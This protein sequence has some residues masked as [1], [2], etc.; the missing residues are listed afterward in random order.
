VTSDGKIKPCL[1]SDDEIDL[2]HALRNDEDILP[3]LEKAI[4]NKPE[5]HDINEENYVPIKR[6]MNRI[7]G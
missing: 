3:I 5:S 1:H 6:N 7:G 2:L 4:E